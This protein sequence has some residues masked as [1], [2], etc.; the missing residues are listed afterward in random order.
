MIAGMSEIPERAA[1]RV[2]WPMLIVAGLVLVAYGLSLGKVLGPP[3]LAGILIYLLLP[4]RRS[5]WVLRTLEVITLAAVL[6][7]VSRFGWVFLVLGI[8]M[9]LAYLLDPAV[10]FLERRHIPRS[11][12]ILI[13]LVPVMAAGVAALVLILPPLIAE[14]GQIIRSLPQLLANIQETLRPLLTRLHLEE[15]ASRYADQIPKV[16]EKTN[17]ILARTLTGV[18]QVTRLVATVVIS[19]VVVPVLTFFFLRDYDRLRSRGEDLIPRKYHDWFDSTSKELD[20]L[21]GRWLRGVAIV[22][23]IVGTL[24]GIGLFALGIPYALALA[25][26]ACVMNVVPYLGFWISFIAAALVTLSAF[27]WTMLLKV[28]LLYFAISLIEGHILQPRVVGGQV[29]LHPVVVLLALVVFANVFGL[30]G[31]LVAVPLTIVL[32]I[33]VR[34]LRALYL[35][36]DL[37][38]ENREG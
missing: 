15:L 16:L 23:L 37:Y 21:L 5:R 32:T 18:V 11:L 12:G 1:P 35:A 17:E 28:T 34:Q 7:L 14:L 13:L 31:A 38:Q 8:S 10:D 24:T 3:L 2:P 22:A 30:I 20:R 36:S 9:F 26:L 4:Y 33:F 29:G 25:A 6:W 19:L 27:G